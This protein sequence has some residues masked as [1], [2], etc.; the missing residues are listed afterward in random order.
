MIGIIDY[1][2][3]N[4]KA[5]VN[6]FDE[7]SIETKII[8]KTE[9][10][11][12]IKCAILP[13]VGSFDNAITKLKSQEYFANLDTLVTE[14]NFPLLGVCIGMQIMLDNSDEGTKAGLSWIN[15]TVKKFND[16]SPL[17]PH[18]GWN[19]VDAINK[20]FIF[21]NL[22]QER[23]FYF[24]H[25]YYVSTSDDNILSS[26][27]HG[28][29]FCSSFKKNNLYGVQFHPEKSHLN[30]MNILRDFYLMYA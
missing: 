25:S 30:G 6:L 12:N 4:L 18:I 19:N 23:E 26:T 1:G 3:G 24:L 7:L 9:D 28:Q 22:D 14:K 11:D 10:L 20:N 27:N 29:T 16:K 21:R 15:G 8:K 17:V 13:G 2:L 5:F